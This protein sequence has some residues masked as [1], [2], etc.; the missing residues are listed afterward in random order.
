MFCGRPT[1]VLNPLHPTQKPHPH[2]IHIDEVYGFCLV[3]SSKLLR[4]IDSHFSPL[5]E[6]GF[7]P[8]H[9]DCC[10]T[11]VLLISFCL[12]S[13]MAPP[14]VATPLKSHLTLGLEVE[15]YAALKSLAFNG[16]LARGC[17]A[18]LLSKRLRHLRLSGP[19]GFG[20]KFKVVVESKKYPCDAKYID[21][22][23]WTLTTDATAQPQNP[24]WFVG[25]EYSNI[26]LSRPFSVKGHNWM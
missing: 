25:C 15:F 1:F 18:S 10:R 21:Y 7:F 13:K 17:M 11:Y 3:E 20:S 23:Q 16:I 4:F 22:A 9:F 8:S 26:P 5:L 19:D 24:E 2:P 12:F 14:P 6:D